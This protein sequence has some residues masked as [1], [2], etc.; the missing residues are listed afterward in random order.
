LVGE[1]TVADFRRYL[2]ISATAFRMGIVSLLRMS[3]QKK[4]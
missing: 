1:S 3:F 4:G 2:R